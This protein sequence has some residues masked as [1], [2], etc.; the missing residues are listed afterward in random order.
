MP[1]STITITDLRALVSALDALISGNDT[2][3]HRA[4]CKRF[5]GVDVL[6]HAVDL[7]EQ[8][9][10]EVA[11]LQTEQREDLDLMA[12]TI[13]TMAMGEAAIQKLQ[14]ELA[15]AHACAEKAEAEL[16]AVLEAAG[17]LL[18]AAN[19]PIAPTMDAIEGRHDRIEAAK[20]QLASLIQAKTVASPMD[21]NERFELL[22]RNF[23]RDT[24]V[25]AHGKDDPTGTRS[26]GERFRLF[27]EWLD[28][29]YAENGG[30][31]ADA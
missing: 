31:A 22:A 23:Y 28:R 19:E 21:D 24:G 25:M 13:P 9:Q 2:D 17:N 14:S 30:V 11:K 10:A 26:H 4:I 5:E 18:R 7:A 15:E 3:A 20:S 1:I 29:Q 16:R 8:L 6:W 12:E 27:R